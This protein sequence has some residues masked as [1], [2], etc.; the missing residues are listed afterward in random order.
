VC[1]SII[2]RG[3]VLQ[4]TTEGIYELSYLE[5]FQGLRWVDLFMVLEKGRS[6]KKRAAEMAQKLKT[7]KTQIEK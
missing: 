1:T 5:I 4:W 6:R 2:C 3:G 7:L